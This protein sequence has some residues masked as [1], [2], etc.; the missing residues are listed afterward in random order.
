MELAIVAIIAQMSN[1]LRTE[2]AIRV[3]TARLC[4]FLDD[5]GGLSTAGI[6]YRLDGWLTP[7]TTVVSSVAELDDEVVSVSAS[8]CGADWDLAEY[9]Q[10]G[11][12]KCPD[13]ACC[14]SNV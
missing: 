13:G 3:V 7:S 14:N 2:L 1:T 9:S 12:I 11:S 8:S 6:S 4:S 10:H 5:G